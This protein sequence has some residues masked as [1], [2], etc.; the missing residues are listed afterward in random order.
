MIY[1]VIITT[2]SGLP[3]L[4]KE[5]QEGGTPQKNKALVSGLL[6]AMSSFSAEVFGEEF[7]KI[8]FKNLEI[9]II[10]LINGDVLLGAVADKG[11]PAAQILL[12]YMAPEI[13]NVFLHDM[14][15]LKGK[16]VKTEFKQQLEE[17]VELH[18]IR[19]GAPNY[20]EIKSLYTKLYPY[21]LTD[22]YLEEYTR[23]SSELSNLTDAEIQKQKDFDT[24]YLKYIQPRELQSKDKKKLLELVE[25]FYRWDLTKVITEAPHIFSKSYTGDLAKLLFTKA[26]ILGWLIPTMDKT[27]SDDFI[28]RVLYSIK[29]TDS[30]IGT[31]K[32]YLFELRKTYSPREKPIYDLKSVFMKYDFDASYIVSRNI[33]ESIH[34][35]Y[36][37]VIFPLEPYFSASWKTIYEKLSARSEI[38]TDFLDLFSYEKDFYSLIYQ[39]KDNEKIFEAITQSR[40]KYLD[41]KQELVKALSSKN[42]KD[43]YLITKLKVHH[44]LAIYRYLLA[45]D[46]SVNSVN[47]TLKDYISLAEDSLTLIKQERNIIASFDELPIITKLILKLLWA[48]F[49]TLSTYQTISYFYS[50]FDNSELAEFA[51][52]V[53]IL[54][55]KVFQLK[56][57]QKIRESDYY[58]FLILI[59]R[60]LALWNR[61]VP[62]DR[63]AIIKFVDDMR[64]IDEDVLDTIRHTNYY[65]YLLGIANSASAASNLTELVTRDI[66]KELLLKKSNDLL[67]RV[68]K[69]LLLIGKVVVFPSLQAAFN[70]YKLMKLT[71][72]KDKIREYYKKAITIIKSLLSLRD[73]MPQYKIALHKLFGDINILYSSLL[74]Q[75]T[76]KKQL[77]LDAIKHYN[78]VTKIIRTLS[79]ADIEWF[80]RINKRIE[81]L[82]QIIDNLSKR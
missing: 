19:L 77:L 59:S 47:L 13:E 28:N 64:K 55:K 78:E 41:V 51:N 24:S 79:K 53:E 1:G 82:T 11:D 46:L 58:E 36:M 70:Y 29:S 43:P 5:L 26:S 3:I 81:K 71:Q 38:I 18:T 9:S 23:F 34:D 72:D 6:S 35:T 8:E 37:L 4:W 67:E 40:L 48:V 62:V 65:N 68:A 31:L 76:E 20:G 7:H 63:I 14:S 44:I 73:I 12:S 33:P 17:I 56:A 16:E 75:E 52:I 49:D 30:T 27:P 57:M 21:I 32:N 42:S 74:Q 25:S 69:L 54:L 50:V 45:L 2:T 15:V 60:A 10:P 39:T 66:D 22:K 80:S 61:S